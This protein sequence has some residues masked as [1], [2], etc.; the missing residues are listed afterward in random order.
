ME[1][2]QMGGRNVVGWKRKPMMR[3]VVEGKETGA[4]QRKNV[5]FLCLNIRGG[6][7]QMT[8]YLNR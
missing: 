5:C 4:K 3:N 6:G 2:E 1:K 8:L 7:T